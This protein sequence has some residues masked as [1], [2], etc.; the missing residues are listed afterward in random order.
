[1]STPG[2][3][4]QDP[5]SLTPVRYYT[6]FD[7]YY[8]SVDNRPLQDL[9]TNITSISSG[10]GDS[11]R[12]AVLLTELAVSSVLRELFSTTNAAG[13]VSGLDVSFLGSNTL[14]IN[15]GALYVTAAL[16]ASIGTAVVKQAL[17]LNN[18]Q[19]T[20]TQPGTAGQ[21]V[22]YLVEAQYLDL[23]AAN[24]PASH[25]PFV[26]ATNSFLPCLLLNGE[27]SL[28]IKVGTAAA[29]GS[30]VTPTV[31]AGWTPLY[32][33]TL[34]N[35]VTN[36]SIALA[37]NA[38]SIRGL[39]RATIPVALPTGGA[40]SSTVAGV[41]TLTFPESGTTGASM[42][43][44]LNAVTLSNG[45][46]PNPYAP[47]KLNLIYSSD[48]AGGNFAMQVKYLAT[49]V[50]D[51]TAGS[52]V[53]STVEAVPM[54]VAANSLLS[55]ST[56]TAVIPAS[57]FSGFVGGSWAVTKQKLFVILQRV[58]GNAADTAAG[59]F[60]LHDVIAYQ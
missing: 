26:D 49:G 41:S 51:S 38:P 12:R 8:F 48:Q 53:S 44:P 35:G 14:Q 17:L 24:M 30:Q 33:V 21:S 58:P 16:N 57:A 56:A 60:Y 13:Y 47:I 55:Y 40:T 15:P 20:V 37:A 6:P 52:Y 22:N 10:G 2:F 28:Q 9:A 39:N 50:G 54:N 19:F 23:S 46:F 36:P 43:I 59:N 29:T 5:N 45:M 34:T 18:V 25:L 27:L 3:V 7:P 32:V 1:M 42:P 31:D 11:A 4:P